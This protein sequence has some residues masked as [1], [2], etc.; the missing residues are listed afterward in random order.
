[1]TTLRELILTRARQRQKLLKVLMEFSY[2]ERLDIKEHVIHIS[3][4]I[5]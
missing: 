1:M 2:F 4:F 5:K 3:C